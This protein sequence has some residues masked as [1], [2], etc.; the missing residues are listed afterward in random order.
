MVDLGV[1][2]ESR[3]EWVSPIVLVGKRDG[4]MRFCVDYRQLNRVAKFDA[5]SM[6]SLLEQEVVIPREQ[7]YSTIDECLTIVWAIRVY[8]CMSMRGISN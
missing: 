1:I 4:S 7:P 8:T 3:S 6:P 5:Y 2:Q